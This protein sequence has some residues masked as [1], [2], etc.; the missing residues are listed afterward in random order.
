MQL[1]N[2]I[3]ITAIA[4]S[5]PAMTAE[6]DNCAANRTVLSNSRAIFTLA[7]LV[8]DDNGKIDVGASSALRLRPYDLSNSVSVYVPNFGQGVE[9]IFTLQNKKLF[10]TGNVESIEATFIGRGDE[11]SR[12]G[13]RSF[14][15]GSTIYDTPAEFTVT[16][17]CDSFG[18]SFPR[19]GG[20]DGKLVIRNYLLRSYP[21]IFELNAHLLIIRPK[22]IHN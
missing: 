18:N 17:D 8:P 6:P 13:W 14:V 15:W 21:V 22:L 3:A 19:L 9:A 2:I 4:F 1:L 11:I 16:E 7:V 12:R 20:A 10:T 5:L